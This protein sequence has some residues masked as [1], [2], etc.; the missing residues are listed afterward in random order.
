M[1]KSNKK[2]FTDAM[3]YSPPIAKTTRKNQVHTKAR[4][5]V[6]KSDEDQVCVRRLEA[7]AKHLPMA[8]KLIGKMKEAVEEL[9]HL[10]LRMKVDSKSNGCFFSDGTPLDR[11]ISGVE[12]LDNNVMGEYSCLDLY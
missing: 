12:E 9:D 1:L 3:T 4:P 5:V 8:S 7:M 11:V 2:A 6:N 10:H